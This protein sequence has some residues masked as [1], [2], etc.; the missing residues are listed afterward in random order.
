MC[1]DGHTTERQALSVVLN[2]AYPRRARAWRPEGIDLDL[3]GTSST[4]SKKQQEEE[5]RKLDAK[6]KLMQE[7]LAERQQ[8][9]EHKKHAT[10]L[11]KQV[12]QGLGVDEG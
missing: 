7:V 9:I 11:E 8:Q 3:D 12:Q 1:V 6:K 5:Q 10:L 4:L 2:L